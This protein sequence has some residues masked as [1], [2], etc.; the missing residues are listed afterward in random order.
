MAYNTYTRGNVVRMT[1][2]FTSGGTLTNPTTVT[3]VL[4]DPEGDEESLTPSN[5]STGV[6]R[7][8]YTIGETAALAPRG[9]WKYRWRGTGAVIA[10]DDNKFF[11]EDDE[12]T[13]D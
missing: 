13:K 6:Y 10:A 4:E 5:V 1:G 3:L 2:T 11:V 12:V 8:D 9:W 7:Y